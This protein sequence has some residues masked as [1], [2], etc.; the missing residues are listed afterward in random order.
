MMNLEPN[1]QT[2]KIELIRESG[3]LLNLLKREVSKV[4]VG[5][6]DVVESIIIAILCNG[7]VLLEGVPGVAKTTMIKAISDSLGFSFK[8]VQFTPDLLPS[9]VIGTLIYNQKTQSFETKQGPIFAN[10]VLADEINRAPAKVQSALLEAMQEQ[11][12]TLGNQTFNL[13][14]PFF[15]F[16]TQNPIEQEGTYQ[17]PEAQL[18]RF[19]FKLNVTY[20]SK[21]DEK[22]ILYKNNL[23]QKIESVLNESDILQ[24]QKLVNEIYLDEKIAD[25]IIDIVHATRFPKEYGAK[26]AN[27]ITMGVSPRASIA[28]YHA[29]KAHA[30]LAG[31]YFVT[32]EDVKQ[33]ACP[34]LRH[35]LVLS[36]EAQADSVTANHLIELLL[37]SVKTP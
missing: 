26:L 34:I 24:A 19:M 17:L 25:Y 3:E 15:V 29:S 6:H 1:N 16:A 10:I 12:V 2:Q 13:P 22:Q 20:P 8:R 18:D 36:Y 31:R 37:N 4:V 33:V 14:R 32:P 5:N 30:L 21:I 9:D 11:Q 35:R 23:H 28:I 27:L 7:H